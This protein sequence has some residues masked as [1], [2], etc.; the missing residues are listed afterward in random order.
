[1]AP[2]TAV[3]APWV[4]HGHAVSNYFNTARAAL[5]EKGLPFEIQRVRASRDDAFLACSPMGKIPFLQTPQ[6][7]LS[8][9]LPLLE[10]LEDQGGGTPLYPVE[11]LP[12]ARLR[13]TLNILQLYL[14]APMRRLYPGTVM[15]GRHTPGAVDD[16]AAQLGIT[17]DALRRLFKLTPYLLGNTLSAGDLFALYCMDIGDRVTRLVYDWSLVERVEGLAEWG[18]RMTERHSTQVV[19][20][21]FIEQFRIYLA[22]KQAAYRLDFGGGI[23]PTS[24]VPAP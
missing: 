15:G 24:S 8:E 9:T 16:V 23:F 2:L 5:M 1:M 3:A 17:L 11:A 4:L 20:A 18:Q 13:Q 14:D 21:E 22:S 19:A 12:R 7:C 10:Y 6:G